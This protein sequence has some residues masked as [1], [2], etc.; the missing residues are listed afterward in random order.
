MTIL[1]IAGSKYIVNGSKAF[2]SGAGA[3]DLLVVMT[4]TGGKGPKGRCRLK[5]FLVFPV[6][7]LLFVQLCW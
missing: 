7:F 4:R 1:L 2:I 3:T 5:L 6:H